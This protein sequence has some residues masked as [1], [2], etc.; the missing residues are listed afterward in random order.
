MKNFPFAISL[1]LFGTGI[2]LLG[3]TKKWVYPSFP[4]EMPPVEKGPDGIYV[5]ASQTP[6]RFPARAL[7]GYVVKEV[8]DTS[9]GVLVLVRST[10]EDSKGKLFAIEGAFSSE[11]PIY[12]TNKKF[13]SLPV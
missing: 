8:K 2:Y 3:R 7:M 6:Y 1:I 12:V 10:R 13:D 11:L 5:F 9:I 4:L